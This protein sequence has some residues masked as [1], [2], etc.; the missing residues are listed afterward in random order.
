MFCFVLF[1]VLFVSNFCSL[2]IYFLILF[3]HRF[4]ATNMYFAQ[5]LTVRFVTLLA[6]N[7]SY[8]EG[9]TIPIAFFQRSKCS[10]QGQFMYIRGFTS[11]DLRYA[12]DNN[13]RYVLSQKLTHYYIPSEEDCTCYNGNVSI[14]KGM[15]FLCYLDHSTRNN[16]TFKKNHAFKNLLKL[17]FSL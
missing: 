16:K 8:F 11:T 15:L 7:H 1:K 12:C 2:I 10:E 4:Q 5:A 17:L 6:T 3:T 13:K 9:R 14:P